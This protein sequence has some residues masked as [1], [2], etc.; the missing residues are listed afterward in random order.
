MRAIRQCPLAKDVF[1]LAKQLELL[2]GVASLSKEYD[3]QGFLPQMVNLRVAPY[4]DNRL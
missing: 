4:L 1:E 2:F 3:V